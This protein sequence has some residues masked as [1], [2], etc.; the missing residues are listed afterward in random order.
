MIA[1]VQRVKSAS[2]SVDN[3]IVG[4]IDH[5]LCVLAAVVKEDTEADARWIVNKLAGL[6]VFPNQEKAY[7]L[8]VR[9]VGGSM[10]LVSNFTVAAETASGRRPGFDRAMAPAQAEAAFARFVQLARET[11]IPIQAGQFGADM[12]VSLVNDGPLTLVVDSRAK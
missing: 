4:S 9:Q 5:G 1:V 12:A 2:V 8:D 6:R 10:L 11:G 7:D 3:Q